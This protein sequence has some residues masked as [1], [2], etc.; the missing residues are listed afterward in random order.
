MARTKIAD[1]DALAAHVLVQR[2]R[3][4]KLTE[5]FEEDKEKLLS[6][7][8][9]LSRSSFDVPNLG[10]CNYVP[11]S[12]RERMDCEAAEVL[13]KAANIVV[14][15]LVSGVRAYIKITVANE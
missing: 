5:K 14:P 8:E 15:T 9:T 11:A 1:I 2:R 7:M 6:L 4:K 3:L 13:L 12:S 10:S